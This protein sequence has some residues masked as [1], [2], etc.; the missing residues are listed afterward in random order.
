[1]SSAASCSGASASVMGP[2]VYRG[3]VHTGTMDP[4][5]PAPR[6]LEQDTLVMQQITG[7]MSN[8]FDILDGTP[9]ASLVWPAEPVPSPGPA[10]EPEPISRPGHRA[11]PPSNSAP[12]LSPPRRSRPA[13]EYWRWGEHYGYFAVVHAPAPVLVIPHHDRAAGGPIPGTSRA[14]SAPRTSRAE[15]SPATSRARPAPGHRAH[16]RGQRSPA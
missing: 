12:R 14:E 5:A 6:R 4:A 7:F 10:T 3:R 2:T 8:D 11:Q 1:M 15:P 16:L 9:L 13:D